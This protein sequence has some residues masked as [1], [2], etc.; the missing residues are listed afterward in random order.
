MIKLIW[1]IISWLAFIFI[2]ELPL[3]IIGWLLIPIAAACKAYEPYQGHDGAGTPRIQHR[4][5]WPIMWLYQNQEDGISNNQ[6]S[7]YQNMFMRIVSW[8]AVRN[9]CNNLRYAPYLSFKIEPN[10]IRFIGSLSSLT[11][12]SRVPFDQELFKKMTM[13]YT[14]PGPSRWVI[15]W[16]GAYSCLYW[17]GLTREFWI[18]FKILPKDLYGVTSYRKDRTGFAMQWRRV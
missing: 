14:L 18:G 5:T 6:Y 16:H 2:I 3:I 4:F 12:N 17:R 9:P 1:F 11:D 7:H 15:C 13:Q 10:N 8:S